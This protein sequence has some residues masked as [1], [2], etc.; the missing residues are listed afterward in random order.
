MKISYTTLACPD[1]SW[2]RILDETVRFGFDGIEIRGLERELDLTKMEPF[3]PENIEGTMK[4]LRE[5]SL[6]ICCLD[7]SCRFHT[8]ADIEKYL[9]E[10]KAAIDLAQKLNC[11]YIRVFGNE[12]PDKSRKAETIKQIASSLDELGNYTK[13]TG[14][15]V[16]IET[17]GD[18]STGDA[19][20]ELLQQITSKNVDVLWDVTNAYVE[21]DEPIDV[22][23]NKLSSRIKHSHIKDA[24]GRVPDAKLCMIGKGDLSVKQMVDLL[25]S[26]G[27]DG[28]L[29]LE[30]EKMWHPELEEPEIVLGTYIKHIKEYL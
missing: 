27:F 1:W 6:E 21:F 12:I 17:H 7:T 4:Q 9:A 29:S 11:K 18:F 26:I 14:V 19:M 3:F 24:K 10:G 16:L 25:K 23:F 8:A 30:W 28:W 13:G 22:T 2:E 15:T 20:L 5:K